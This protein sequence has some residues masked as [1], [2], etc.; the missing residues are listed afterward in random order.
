MWEEF[1]LLI[2]WVTFLSNKFVDDAIFK[3]LILA[4]YVDDSVL[5]LFLYQQ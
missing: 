4:T 2:V 3:F 5:V 1:L